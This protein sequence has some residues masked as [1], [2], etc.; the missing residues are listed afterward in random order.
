MAVFFS[1]VVLL[2][3][4]KRIVSELCCVR[5]GTE[6]EREGI[7]AIYLCIPLNGQLSLCC[8]TLVRLQNESAINHRLKIKKMKKKEKQKIETKRRMYEL[9]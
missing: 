8:R 7:A 6:R 2:T 3:P 5:R 4:S 1:A 9:M